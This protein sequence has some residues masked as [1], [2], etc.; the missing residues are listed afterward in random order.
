MQADE[1]TSES[2]IL[3]S[4]SPIRIDGELLMP[5]GLGVQWAEW[6]SGAE[7]VIAKDLLGVQLKARKELL[8]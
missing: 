4:T 3:A 8:S 1:V 2:A 7:Q 5:G 6:A